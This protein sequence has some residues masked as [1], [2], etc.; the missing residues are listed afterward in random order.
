VKLVKDINGHPNIVGDGINVAQRIMSFAEPGQVL[1]SRSYFD[2]VSCLSDDYAKLFSYDGSRTDKHVRE[3]EVYVVGDSE[4]AF[5]RAKAGMER[6]AAGSGPKPAYKPEAGG[7]GVRGTL[8]ERLAP[9]VTAF[10]RDRRKV[11]MAGGALGAVVL[12]LAGLLVARKP[13]APQ[14]QPTAQAAAAAPAAAASQGEPNAPAA[15]PAKP[16]HAATAVAKAQPAKKEPPRPHA[17][18]GLVKLAV[19]PWGEVYVNGKSRGV[20]PP[21]KSLK[22]APGKYRIEVRNSNLAP[23]DETIEV[24]SREEVT[25]R[26]NFK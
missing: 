18:P 4:S 8:L 12:L 1:V 16:A 2:V 5:T 19:D 20:S 23:Y 9:A 15:A 7:E 26:H 14:L 13:A 11:M 10:L 22:L 6:R 3:H 21:I 25:I 17:A 24:K